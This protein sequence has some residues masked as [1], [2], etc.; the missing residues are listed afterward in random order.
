[1]EKKVKLSQ[2]EIDGVQYRRA[3]LWQIILISCNAFVGMSVYS[4]IGLASY[5]ASLGFGITTAVVGVVL[6]WTRILDGITDPM[7][8]F[9]YDRVNTRFGKIRILLI[10]GYIIEAAALMAMFVWGT[11]KGLGIAGFTIFYIIY[12]IGYTIANMTALTISP[13]ISNDPRQRPTIGVWSTALNYLVPMVLSI[14][15][16]SV[17]LPQ[18][19]G[20]YTL[21]FLAAAC[22]LCLVVAGIG[23]ILVCI[24]VTPYDKPENFQSLDKKESSLK[25]KDMIEI[26]KHNRPLQCYIISNASD[27]IAQQT[28]SQSVIVTM[29]NGI[30]IGNMG[31][32][33]ILSVIGM[34][35]SILFAVA[36]AKYA[37]K[38][39]SQTTIVT[40]TRICIVISV[41]MWGFMI[42]IDPKQIAVP[43]IC[44]VLY[45]I[46]TLLKNGANMCVTTAGSAFMCDIIDYEQDRSGRYVP[47]VITGVYG[48]I[49]KIVSS[50]SALIATG[51]VALIGYTSTMPQP[52]DT[53]TPKIFWATTIITFGFPILGWFCTLIAM[54]FC[55]LTKEDMV[56]VQKRI[57][58]RKAEAELQMEE[59]IL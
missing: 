52:T 2:S 20:N 17:M 59:T 45:V 58:A 12:V 54:K 26:V 49:D 22:R 48:F 19:G 40:W 51:T 15:L 47:A 13:L 42:V 9:I 35:P 3:K 11:E 28:T 27:K 16:N 33:T 46:F 29:L 25:I 5:A 14:I 56:E 18:F 37:G 4:L 21:E 38:F 43:G 53:A 10:T 31:L 44:M 24:G 39:G 34:L 32:A 57:A 7:L 30:L 6:T 36:G 50:F 41:I 1:M 55:H 8:A 23:I